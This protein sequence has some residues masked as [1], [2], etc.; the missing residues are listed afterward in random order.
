M[1]MRCSILAV[2]L[3]ALGLVG[4]CASQPPTFQPLEP[5][6][7]AI[8]VRDDITY[9]REWFFLVDRF[10]RQFDLEVVAKESGYI[11]TAWLTALNNESYALR[12]TAKLEPQKKVLQFKTEARFKTALGTDSEFTALLKTDVTGSLGRVAK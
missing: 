1:P 12:V 7:I 3:L 5:G 8:E 2:A 10:S 11:R 4:G 6:W 9:D